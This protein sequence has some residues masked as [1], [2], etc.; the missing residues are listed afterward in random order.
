MST[1]SRQYQYVGPADIRETAIASSPPGAPIVS[2]EDLSSWIESCPSSTEPDGSLIATFTINVDSVLLLAPRRSE[3]V[4]CVGGGLVL[5]AGEITFSADGDV[6]EIT[7][8]STGFCPEPESWPAVA[9]VL[10][11]I[12]VGRPDD[13]TTCVVFRLCPGCKE[14]NIVKDGW[15]V[16][17]LCGVDLP[18]NWNFPVPS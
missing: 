5:S 12:P 14:R 17:D 16:C 18:Q 15:F 11:A 13:F 9:A 7:N 2:A 3:H 1:F 4:A 8:Q 10:D 6:S